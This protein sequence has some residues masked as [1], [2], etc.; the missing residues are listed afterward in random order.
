MNYVGEKG[1]LYPT[2]NKLDSLAQNW[3]GGSQGK[4]RIHRSH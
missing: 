2:A 3:G 1:L 4:K